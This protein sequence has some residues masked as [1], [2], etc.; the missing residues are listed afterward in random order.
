[1]MPSLPHR[2]MSGH[3]ATAS[4]QKN[5]S[6]RMSHHP[7]TGIETRRAKMELNSAERNNK[8]EYE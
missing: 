4:G 6:K 3:F 5:S 2:V 7:D 8:S 1:M